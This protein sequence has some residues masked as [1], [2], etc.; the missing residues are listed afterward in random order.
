M[1]GSQTAHSVTV[2]NHPT[3]C[4]YENISPSAH[5]D[6][7]TNKQTD[8]RTDGQTNK[9]RKK[10]TNKKTKERTNEQTKKQIPFHLPELK[11][12]LCQPWEFVIHS[13][14]VK[15]ISIFTC[16]HRHTSYTVHKQTYKNYACRYVNTYKHRHK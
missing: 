12:I 2:L 6:T 8:G 11:S 14:H 4:I 3:S 1:T 13:D 16:I 9:Q 15:H 10:Q 7:Q 5:T